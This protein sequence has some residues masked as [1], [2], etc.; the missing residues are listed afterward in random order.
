[1]PVGYALGIIRR[2]RPGLTDWTTASL[3]GWGMV[4]VYGRNTKRNPPPGTVG[5]FDQ[6]SAPVRQHHE[7]GFKS[8]PRTQP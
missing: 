4:P 6:V 7:W 3:T 2:A 1:M 8:S 5:G